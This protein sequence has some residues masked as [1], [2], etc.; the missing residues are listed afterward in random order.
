VADARDPKDLPYAELDILGGAAGHL[1]GEA[2]LADLAR[3]WCDAREEAGA[4]AKADAQALDRLASAEEDRLLGELACPSR[5]LAEVALKLAYALRVGWHDLHGRS[6]D[7]DA[8][9]TLLGTALSDVVLLREAEAQRRARLAEVG[10]RDT[11][12]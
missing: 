12:K 10:A 11:G 9:L 3:A 2:V 8:A 7:G 4:L 5:G 6:T 1:A